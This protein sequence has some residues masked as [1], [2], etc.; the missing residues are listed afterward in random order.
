MR[1]RSCAYSFCTHASMFGRRLLQNA[2]LRWVAAAVEFSADQRTEACRNMARFFSTQIRQ[3][4]TL[5][6]VSAFAVLKALHHSH[7]LKAGQK[8]VADKY[9]AQINQTKTAAEGKASAEIAQLKN[10]LKQTEASAKDTV[11]QYNA[12]ADAQAGKKMA[13]LRK[14]NRD[15]T[16]KVRA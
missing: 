2:I 6:A 11:E 4:E 16:F 9:K 13:Q 5:G 1:R 8:K 3:N 10:K 14:E 7:Q 15:L 12:A